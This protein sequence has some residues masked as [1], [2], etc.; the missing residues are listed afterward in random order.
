ME[1]RAPCG[2]RDSRE[3]TEGSNE[4]GVELSKRLKP[5]KAPVRP[6]WPIRSKSTRGSDAAAIR[7][8]ETRKRAE[9]HVLSGG[10]M[11]GEK[12]S[13]DR[14]EQGIFAL[15]SL[16]LV[17][18]KEG[19]L[20]LEM[21]QSKTVFRRRALNQLVHILTDL[22]HDDR[23]FFNSSGGH[24]LDCY[25]RQNHLS[26][27][28]GV[29]IRPRRDTTHIWHRSDSLQMRRSLFQ[30]SAATVN[31]CITDPKSFSLGISVSNYS[32]PRCPPLHSHVVGDL[33]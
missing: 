6:T 28:H 20:E 30:G 32:G 2:V 5:A 11:M 33:L 18:Y 21:K 3:D 1:V 15:A 10:N 7:A 31:C 26:A 12:E 16:V 8:R 29:L 22:V 14:M 4:V 19:K 27:Q 25:L 13:R 17:S 24:V 23:W 9:D